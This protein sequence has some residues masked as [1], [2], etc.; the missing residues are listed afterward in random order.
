MLWFNLMGLKLLTANWKP[1]LICLLTAAALWYF[2]DYHVS[3][4][5]DARGVRSEVSAPLSPRTSPT[6]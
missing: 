5:R 6:P 2:I 4:K 3:P 1:K